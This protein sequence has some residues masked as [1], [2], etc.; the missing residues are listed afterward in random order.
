[1]A[2]MTLRVAWFPLGR[3]LQ[4]TALVESIWLTLYI[5]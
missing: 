4:L 5:E 1:M 3:E 2:A